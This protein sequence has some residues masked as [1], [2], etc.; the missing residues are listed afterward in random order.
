MKSKNLVTMVSNFKGIRAEAQKMRK[1]TS[2]VYF[3]CCNALDVFNLLRYYFSISEH[4]QLKSRK[5]SVHL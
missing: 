5:E 3:S 4:E 2:T 1:A